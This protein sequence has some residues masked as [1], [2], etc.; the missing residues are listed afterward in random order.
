MTKKLLMT[1]LAVV[2]A[3]GIGLQP[4]W[5][6]PERDYEK[7]RGYEKGHGMG[8][9]HCGMGGRHASTGHL[10]RGLLMSEKEFGLT[11]EQVAKLKAIQLDLDKTRI[12]MEADIMI[13][14]REAQALVD[15]DKSELVAIEAKVKESENLEV[16]LRVAAIKARRDVMALLTPEQSAR[17]K[18]VHDK[19]MMQMKERHGGKGEGMG[20]GMMKGR[21]PGGHP[22]G[23]AKKGEEKKEPKQ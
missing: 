20:H 11:G 13:A 23:E 8:C 10:I 5:A 18:A 19:M 6:A 4:A 2:G 17:V 16:S 7:E 9:S 12:K 1:V 14:E 22:K 3:I 15:D 21:G